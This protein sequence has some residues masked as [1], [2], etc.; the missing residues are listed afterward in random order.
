MRS[1]SLNKFLMRRFRKISKWR[2]NG[3]IRIKNKK[4]MAI[5]KKMMRKKKKAREKRTVVRMMI[6]KTSFRRL[7]VQL[8]T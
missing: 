8:R 2:I 3:N 5:N 6:N 4:M 7:A 1:W